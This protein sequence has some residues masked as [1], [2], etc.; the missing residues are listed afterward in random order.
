MC[1]KNLTKRPF[2]S[3]KDIVIFADIV[4]TKSVARNRVS[5]MG[6][7]LTHWGEDAV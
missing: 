2:F 6:C 3:K 4:Y 1:P 7:V 5:S